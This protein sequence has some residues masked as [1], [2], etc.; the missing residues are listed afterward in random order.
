MPGYWHRSGRRD[1]LSPLLGQ[2]TERIAQAAAVVVKYADGVPQDWRL[3][4][5]YNVVAALSK[6]WPC[7]K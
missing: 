5:T 3:P 7:S 4:L 6:A 2:M 1:L